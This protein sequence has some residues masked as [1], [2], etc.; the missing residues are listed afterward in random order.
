MR[1]LALLFKDTFLIFAKKANG[2]RNPYLVTISIQGNKNNDKSSRVGS[3]KPDSF[4][5]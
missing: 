3:Q 1:V 2:H 5:L 4:K